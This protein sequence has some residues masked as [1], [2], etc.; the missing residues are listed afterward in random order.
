MKR[1]SWAALLLA[2]VATAVTAA[3]ILGRRARTR[4]SALRS[5]QDREALTRMEGEGGH[6]PPP[7]AART[8]PK[9]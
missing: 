5:R 9:R 8:S 4:T 3:F 7:T 2:G 6:A 1:K